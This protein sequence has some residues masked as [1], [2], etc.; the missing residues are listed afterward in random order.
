MRLLLKYF[1]KAKFLKTLLNREFGG[2]TSLLAPEENTLCVLPA[3]C[4]QE[5]KATHGNLLFTAFAETLQGECAERWL[6]GKLAAFLPR[7]VALWRFQNTWVFM[8]C[9]TPEVILS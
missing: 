1:T 7:D 4:Y 9:S 5:Q 2:K 8:C 6:L 3:L